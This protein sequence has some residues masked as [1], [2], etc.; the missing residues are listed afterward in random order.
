MEWTGSYDVMWAV[1]IAL[2][3]AAALVHLPIDERPA[4]NPRMAAA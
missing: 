1:D 3:V 4:P 2:A